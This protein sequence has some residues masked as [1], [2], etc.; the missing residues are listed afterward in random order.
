MG[1]SGGW[2]SPRNKAVRVKDSYFISFTRI[3]PNNSIKVK[4]NC[5]HLMAV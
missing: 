4:T 3:I 5:S 1:C 2:S